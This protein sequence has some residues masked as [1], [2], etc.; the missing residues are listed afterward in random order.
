MKIF[1][2][3]T[4]AIACGL[5]LAP[6]RSAEPAMSPPK[7]EKAP[8]FST[9]QKYLKLTEWGASGG[10]RLTLADST[11]VSELPDAD[12]PPGADPFLTGKKQTIKLEQAAADAAWAKIDTFAIPKWRSIYDARDLGQ[13]EGS[14][15]EWAIDA[16][17]GKQK[18]QC[19]GA[20][21]FPGLNPLGMPQL[22]GSGSGPDP[23]TAYSQLSTLLKS[24][25]GTAN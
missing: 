13:E 11:L 23:V 19:Q 3:I 5:G 16:R 4:L 8:D 22:G 7:A 15:T 10:R 9:A 25:A 17:F 18:I 12:A 14:G 1:A 21:A 2:V 24:L 20:N 6:L